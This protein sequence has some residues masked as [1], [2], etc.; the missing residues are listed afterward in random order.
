MILEKRT[1]ARTNNPAKTRLDH[2]FVSS[3]VTPPLRPHTPPRTSQN[4]GTSLPHGKP[5]PLLRERQSVFLDA[6]GWQGSGFGPPGHPA[7][8]GI[9]LLHGDPPGRQAGVHSRGA[10]PMGPR[11]AYF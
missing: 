1:S 8:L 3:P 6:S 11:T 7:L 4:V 5:G 2:R 9:P 10:G